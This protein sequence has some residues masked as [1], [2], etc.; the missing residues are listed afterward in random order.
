MEEYI[1]TSGR[2]IYLLCKDTDECYRF[3]AYG[4][5]TEKLNFN[6]GVSLVR[7]IDGARIISIL[8]D[9]TSNVC[10]I[11][12]NGNVA[13]IRDNYMSVYNSIKTVVNSLSHIPLRISHLE[14]NSMQVLIPVSKSLDTENVLFK[15]LGKLNWIRI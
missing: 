13:V 12:L 10:E 8:G 7:F 4:E 11:Y 15:T 6:V 2:D 5:G 9:P 1:G 3:N 14:E